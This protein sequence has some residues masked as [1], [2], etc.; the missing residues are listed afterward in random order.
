LR[1]RRGCRQNCRYEAEK[2]LSHEGPPTSR[3]N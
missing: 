2:S 3:F 1:V